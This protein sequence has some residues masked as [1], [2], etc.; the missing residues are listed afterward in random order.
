MK[1]LFAILV[2]AL[3]AAVVAPTAYADSPLSGL[4]KILKGAASK[5]SSSNTE[6]TDG[7]QK[8]GGLGD[9][10]SGVTSA[11]GIG[12]KTNATIDDL[13][14]S[15]AYTGP[16]VTFKSENLLMKAGGA[17]AS[18]TIEKKIANY[19]KI[20][21]LDNLKLTINADS[22]FTMQGRRIKLNGVISY[23]AETSNYMFQ[24]KALGKIN[25]GKMNAYITLN[26]NNM[27][28]TFDVTKLLSIVEK[29]GSITK[30]ST[31]SGLTKVL[32]QYDG[33][34]AGFKLKKTA[35]ATKATTT[36]STTTTTKK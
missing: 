15:W 1:K 4:G 36:E 25:M 26:G 9:L 7:D 28:L 35:E 30:N 22:T 19:Y 31:I 13:A 20:A 23:N 27:Q 5:S 2:L 3:S 6:T 14:G 24:F 29:V 11:L 16:A 8:K 17:A 12:T 21:G 33:M 32:N 34:T 10:I 18:A